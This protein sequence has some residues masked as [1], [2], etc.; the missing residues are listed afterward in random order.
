MF[1]F[2]LVSTCQ[3]SKIISAQTCKMKTLC[4]ASGENHCLFCSIAL[5]HYLRKC[6]R[7]YP[8]ERKLSQRMGKGRDW[9]HMLMMGSE[10]ALD[11]SKTQTLLGRFPNPQ[12]KPFFFSMSLF[13]D[14]TQY[15]FGQQNPHNSCILSICF[16]LFLAVP[17]N[18]EFPGQ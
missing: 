10:K 17:S 5:L 11:I 8:Q 4:K 12:S 14:E 15:F 2:F 6:N 1:V 16:F 7:G 9:D 13:T 3:V 18:M